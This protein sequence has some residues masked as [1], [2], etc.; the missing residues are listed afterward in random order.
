MLNIETILQF[1][2][3]RGVRDQAIFY[4]NE[5]FTYFDEG[6]TRYVF[7]NEDKTRVVKILIDAN[8]KDFNLDEAERYENAS[9]EV[10]KE[11]AETKL[12]MDGLLVEQ[13]FCNPIKFDDRPLTIPQIQFASSCRDEVGWNKDGELVCF[14][15]DEYKKY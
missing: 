6:L 9:E 5:V 13:E 8:S 3:R 11:M 4:D 2:H 7:V 12:V 10:R 1:Q 14:D 15:L